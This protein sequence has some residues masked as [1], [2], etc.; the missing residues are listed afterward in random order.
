MWT[1]SRPPYVRH[2]ADLRARI[3]SGDLPEAGTDKLPSVAQLMEDFETTST[4]VV[5]RAIAVLA[6]EGLVDVRRGRGTYVAETPITPVLA[7]PVINPD[8][9]PSKF[10]YELLEVGDV[11]APVEVA[12]EYKIQRG[13]AVVLRKQVGY[14]KSD[15]QPVE[16]VWNYYLTA[17]AHGTPLMEDA[18]LAGGAKAYFESVGRFQTEMDDVLTGRA[19][20]TEEAKALR[21]PAE[22]FVMR[23]LRR[24]TDQDGTPF[25][26]SVIAKGTHLFA[27]RHHHV[28]R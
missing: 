14:S 22:A 5:Q 15:G 19:P 1:D 23:T 9:G 20:T 24:I 10:R 2:A 4:S 11:P 16:L 8:G 6:S 25:E 13:A 17:D 3:M 26:V 28:L 7:T 12:R 18:K 21:L 27:V